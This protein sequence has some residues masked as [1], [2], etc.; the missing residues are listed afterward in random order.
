M[1]KI[2]KDQ[3]RIRFFYRNK[4]L[5]ILF[6]VLLDYHFNKCFN[7][8]LILRSFDSENIFSSQIPKLLKIF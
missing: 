2:L 6:F 3:I 5:I 4:S 7:G 1:E 8:L